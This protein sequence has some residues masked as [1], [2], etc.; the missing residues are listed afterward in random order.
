MHTAH[1]THHNGFEKTSRTPRITCIV[2]RILHR[3][4]WQ[5]L[6]RAYIILPAHIKYILLWSKLKYNIRIKKFVCFPFWCVENFAAFIV[7]LNFQRID[8]GG[9]NRTRRGTYNH[10]TYTTDYE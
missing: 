7:Y 9:S 8:S 10:Y 5:K 6:Y 1:I 2:L 3:A 4:R